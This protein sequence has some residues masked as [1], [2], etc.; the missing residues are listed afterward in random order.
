MQYPTL[1]VIYLAFLLTTLL[2]S[3]LVYLLLSLPSWFFPGRKL[4]L[5]EW[6]PP[7]CV[8]NLLSVLYQRVRVILFCQRRKYI[9]GLNM[10]CLCTFTECLH[11]VIAMTSMR[12]WFRRQQRARGSSNFRAPNSCRSKT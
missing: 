1:E 12:A 3:V 4:F 5:F 10:C 6:T 9:T 7:K 11:D 8:V 2:E